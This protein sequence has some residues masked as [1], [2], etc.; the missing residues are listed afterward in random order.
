MSN[1]LLTVEGLT[2]HFRLEAKGLFE[3]GPLLRAVDGVDFVLERGETLGL[4]GPSGAGKSTIVWSMLRFFDPQ[5]GRIL[6]GGLNIRDIP[7]AQLRDQVAVVTQ[8]TYLFHGT[9][10]DNL[11]F[12]GPNAT[13]DQLIAAA[14]SANAHEFISHL[15]QG[16]DTIV[17][18]RA[19][20]LSG[21]QKQRIAIARA[22]LKDAP[23]L[24]LD[25]ALSSVDAENEAVIQEALDNLMEGRTT[26]IIAH[27]LSSVVKADRIIVLEDGRLVESGNHG[28][29]VAAGGVYAEL[30]ARSGLGEIDLPGQNSR[31][32]WPAMKDQVAAVFKQR[33][34]DEWCEL[35]EHSD[36]C[37]APVLSLSEA[38]QHPHNV[39]RET[40]TRVNGVIQPSP[41]PRFSGTEAKLSRPPAHAG[42]HTDE[43]L[44]DIGLSEED[45]AALRDSGAIA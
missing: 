43:L 6:L 22:L 26:L 41:S 18:E 19:V 7:L 30:M 4:V 36:V 20:R 3:K 31:S 24:V 5:N 35:M 33:T 21:G 15:P 45:V 27:R 44:A 34:R 10:A 9:V 28:K 8:D 2:K 42:Q 37:F 32:D 40:F 16:Y 23:I 13:E 38:P 17:G 11:R 25:E 12:G 14:R 29:L 39:E 1:E